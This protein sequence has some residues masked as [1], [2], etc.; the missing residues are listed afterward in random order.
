MIRLSCALVLSTLVTACERGASQQSQ[1]ISNQTVAVPSDTARLTLE[2][3]RGLRFLQGSWRGQGGDGTSFFETY[4][5]VD[6]STIA[7]TAWRDSS[8]ASA[9]ELSR[10]MWRGGAVATADGARLVRVDK[11]GF[12]FQAPT[13]RWSFQPVSADRWLAR[14]GPSTVYTMDRVASR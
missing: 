8:M 6:D 2:E 5:F 1:Q 7:M 4:E 14:V 11:D 10:Y 3:F 9:R 13:Y 12:H